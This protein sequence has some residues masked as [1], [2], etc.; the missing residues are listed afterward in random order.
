[1]RTL[2]LAAGA[3]VMALSVTHALAGA[4]DDARRHF[5]AIAAGQVDDIMAAYGDKARFEWIGGPLNGTYA[6]TDEIRGVWSKFAKA[7]AP[8]KVSVAKLEE[9]ANP[10]GSTV[11][12]N[13]EFSGKN[14]IKVRYALTYRDGR[15]VN[16]IWQIDPK[17][18]SAAY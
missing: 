11:T 10:Q 17:L 1:M 18:S 12:A 16:E 14:T 5:D 13:V 9:S 4:S 15:L 3:V 6:G 7:N 8:L 2:S